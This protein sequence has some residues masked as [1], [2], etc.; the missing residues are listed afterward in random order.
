MT[1]EY[2]WSRARTD[3]GRTPILALTARASADRQIAAWPWGAGCIQGCTALRSLDR[4][5]VTYCQ[6]AS[7]AA[8][9]AA[10]LS[11]AT[12]AIQN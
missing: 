3:P 11:F 2:A 8:V 9:V 7:L 6:T 4:L 1:I 12:T 10:S 5:P